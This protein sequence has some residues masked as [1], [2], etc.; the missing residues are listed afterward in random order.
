LRTSAPY[1]YRDAKPVESAEAFAKRLAVDLERLIESEGPETVGAFIAEPVMGAGGVIVPP[2]TYFPK[3]QTVLDRH[4]VLM[5]ADEVICGFGRLGTWFGSQALDI[6]PDIMTFAKGVTSGYQPLSGC[7][8]SDRLWNELLANMGETQVFGHGFTYSAHP[9]A[10]A[11]GLANMEIMERENLIGNAATSGA[12]LQEMLAREIG[13]HPL[14]GEVRGLGL[15]AG[16]ELSASKKARVPFPAE[17]G[18][19]KRV[20]G[21][22][23]KNGL[24]T[25]P[26]LN[27][28]ILAFSPPLTIRPAEI[29]EMVHRL[30]ISL[31]AALADLPASARPA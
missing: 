13:P 31:D 29:D 6:R 28:D 7:I 30:R 15:I 5:I 10:A 16:I 9:V 26:L 11:A 2:A 4:D 24:L 1:P 19:A 22:A 18:I 17:I 23:L 25:R 8:V 20:T 27:S 12:Y 21:H 3:I 14:V